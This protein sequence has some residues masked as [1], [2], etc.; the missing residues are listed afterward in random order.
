MRVLAGRGFLKRQG[1]THC[2]PPRMLGAPSGGG[3]RGAGGRAV[4]VTPDL[5]S[6]AIGNGSHARDSRWGAG[7][8]LVGCEGYRSLLQAP[9]P[10]GRA[11][12]SS[13]QPP[14][15][16]PGPLGPPL[17]PRHQQQQ[18]H[19][20]ADTRSHGADSCYAKAKRFNIRGDS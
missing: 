18:H 11:Q 14:D 10:A 12:P 5:P 13:V 1:P 17:S 16:P 19:Q 4:P 20:H 9:S 6:S 15:W 8:G 3:G 7:A 2:T